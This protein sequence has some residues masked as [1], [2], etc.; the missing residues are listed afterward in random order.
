MK[1][2][3]LVA[4]S[5]L[6][7][8]WCS[9]NGVEGIFK[10]IKEGDQKHQNASWTDW[11]TSDYITSL[12][13]G[14]SL[15]LSG[16]GI[17]S[18]QEICDLLSWIDLWGIKTLDLSDNKITSGE[19]LDCFPSLED[20]NLSWNQIDS[21]IGFPLMENIE[22][23]NMARNKLKD[24]EWIEFLNGVIELQLGENYLESLIGLENLE[25]LEKLSVE[26]NKLKDLDLLK[27]L[28]KLK[29]VN[30]QYNDIKGSIQEL[31]NKI[32]NFSF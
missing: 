14:Q 5:F 22:K 20:L 9:Q 29:D 27:Q 7:L 15:D 16:L 19:W 17:W 12:I 32:P 24:L 4:C 26:F 10:D 6:L 3:L 18:I 13:D 30:A 2:V 11:L 25:G 8:V 23:L 21:F 31:L 1:K 28:D